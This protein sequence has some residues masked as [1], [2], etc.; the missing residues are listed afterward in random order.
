MDSAERGQE[1]NITEETELV[2]NHNPPVQ[3]NNPFE[4]HSEKENQF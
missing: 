4:T 2:I 3:P 1:G